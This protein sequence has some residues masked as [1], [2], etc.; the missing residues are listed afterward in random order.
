MDKQEKKPKKQL[1]EEQL[2]DSQQH[3]QPGQQKDV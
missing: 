2:E 1:T 3:G